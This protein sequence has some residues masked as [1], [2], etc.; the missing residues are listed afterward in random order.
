MDKNEFRVLIKHCFLVGKNTVRAKQWLDKRYGDSAPG[1]STIID[2]YA[3]FKRGRTN[4]DALNA[5]FAQNQQLF[6]KT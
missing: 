6:R 5:L 3:E 1:K 2:W 4:T